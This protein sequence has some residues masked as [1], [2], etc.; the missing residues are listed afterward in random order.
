MPLT[1]RVGSPRPCWRGT[2]ARVKPSR[3]A[4]RSAASQAVDRSQL[5]GQADL[6]TQHSA[7]TQRPIAQRRGERQG[8]RQVERR[9]VDR[10]AADDAGVDIVAGEVHAGTTAEHGDQQRQTLAIEPAAVRRGEP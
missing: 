2:I 5:A 1:S 8:E 10:Q 4:S 9:L 3:A 7:G 6:A